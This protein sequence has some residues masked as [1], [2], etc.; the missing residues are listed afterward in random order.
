[1]YDHPD[2]WSSREPRQVDHLVGYNMSFR[3]CAIECFET[4]LR[5]YWQLFELDV[6]LTVR[7]NGYRVM[8]DF[9]NVVEHHPTNATYAGGRDGDLQ[10]KIYNGAYNKAFVLAKHSKGLM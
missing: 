9:G 2:E 7:D 5:R 3:R 6:C 1:M 10:V 4:N 8:F